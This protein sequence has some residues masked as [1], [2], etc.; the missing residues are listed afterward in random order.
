MAYVTCRSARHWTATKRRLGFMTVTQDGD[1]EGCLRL[2]RLPTPEESA[3]IRDT[4][5]LRK[6]RTL[7]EESRTKLIA[8]GVNGRFQAGR[9]A[10]APGSIPDAA[11]TLARA[12]TA[13]NGSINAADTLERKRAW[14][15]KAG[16]ARGAARPPV[17]DAPMPPD[18]NGRFQAE[19]GLAV[20]D[21][22][23]PEVEE[24]LA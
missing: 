2:F 21:E 1:D 16:L 7:T 8:A 24:A 9:A 23:V 6:R 14:M 15:A 18:L 12:K 5:G 3:L 22:G 20:E 19:G 10:T 13:S 17:P 4:L 11:P